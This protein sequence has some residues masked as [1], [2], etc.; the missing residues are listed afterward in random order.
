MPFPSEWDESGFGEEL[1]AV[2][3]AGPIDVGWSL[4]AVID[5]LTTVIDGRV[6]D[7]S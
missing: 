3:Q 6:E 2:L 5:E 4:L 1:P 7:E